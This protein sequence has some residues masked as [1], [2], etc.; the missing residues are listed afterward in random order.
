MRFFPSAM[1]DTAKTVL[2]VSA[3]AAL[4]A[5]LVMGGQIP[6]PSAFSSLPWSDVKSTLGGSTNS[7]IDG[8]TS[9]AGAVRNSAVV[10]SILNPQSGLVHLGASRGSQPWVICA[11]ADTNFQ[12]DEGGF[13]T[14]VSVGNPKSF[15][16]LSKDPAGDSTVFDTIQE[17][18]T[19]IHVVYRS[20]TDL[21]SSNV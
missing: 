6:N 9:A 17:V 10:S 21:S 13:V 8:A 11:R 19:S 12:S 4:G 2:G 18:S 7:V 1:S 15:A 16:W 3:A 5:G 20:L 14:D